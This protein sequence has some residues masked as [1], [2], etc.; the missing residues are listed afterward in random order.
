M[1][2]RLTLAALLRGIEGARVQAAP[3]TAGGGPAGR[4]PGEV[5][6]LRDDSRLVEPG[7]VE[8]VGGVI[9]TS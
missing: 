3:G 4:Q 2:P 8:G 5:R 9:V 6:E 1:A 7:D